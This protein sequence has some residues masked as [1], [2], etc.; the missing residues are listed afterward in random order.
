MKSK[1]KVLS[2]T[3]VGFMILILTF[4][5]GAEDFY[6]ICREGSPS[7]IAE[8]IEDGAEVNQR[9]EQGVTPLMAA[10]KDNSNYQALVTLYNNDAYV[11]ARDD[12]GWNAL[13]YA[14]RYNENLDVIKI[15]LRMNSRVNIDDQDGDT[16]LIL[17][18]KYRNEKIVR[19]LLS[20][21]AN[22]N[23]TNN[24][25]QTPLMIA[26]KDKFEVNIIDVL[27]MSG[28]KVNTRDNQGRTPIYYVLDKGNYSLIRRFIIYGAK[29]EVSDYDGF[30][31][32]M[33]A[34]KE[35]QDERT[36]KF[37]NLEDIN[38][39]TK[40]ENGMTALMY[41]ARY[42]KDQ[43]VLNYL[44]DQGAHL[45]TTDNKGN[46]ALA[47]AVQHNTY[48]IV[49]NLL[50][51]G[52][53]LQQKNVGG[54]TPLYLAVESSRDIEMISLLVE[55]G[56]NVKTRDKFT[57]KTILMAAIQ[58]YNNTQVIQYLIDKG[59][60]PTARDNNNKRIVDY[61]EQNKSLKDTDLYWRLNYLEPDKERKELLD[62][63]NKTNVGITAAVFPSGGHIMLDRWWP[64]G[65]LFMTGEVSALIAAF[66]TE[67]EGTRGT[68]LTIFGL[69]K[70]IEIVD[71][72]NET[73]KY[74]EDV[75]EYNE[76]VK[77]F[78]EEIKK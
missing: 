31:P 8:A 2:L 25:G 11:N 48:N 14:V 41:A 67:D 76:R 34:A 69:L 46:N 61:L 44:I 55:R 37:F 60:N 7:E 75:E 12:K 32:L 68:A 42:N 15:L 13:M 28:A 24:R 63:K 20:H 10:A 40:D 39:N 29:L 57:G 1:Y 6:T 30:T 66:S 27:L 36:L 4:S 51:R 65:T 78:N 16:P 73:E 62:F 19:T 50:N 71:V 38:F 21:G 59:A 47:Y 23:R 54:K 17:A 9:N 22:V 64:K 43:K 53:S 5:V 70:A 33:M 77:E 74:N 45:N 3:V 52:A 18:I 56:A 35:V 26:I 72:L 58:N 49:Q